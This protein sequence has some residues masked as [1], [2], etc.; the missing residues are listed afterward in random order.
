MQTLP[1]SL[2]V[3]TLYQMCMIYKYAFYSQKRNPVFSYLINTPIKYMNDNQC[4]YINSNHDNILR[5][6]HTIVSVFSSL[7]KPGAQLEEQA[8]Y[9]RTHA[10][11]QRPVGSRESRESASS[12]QT[13]CTAR[14]LDVHCCSGSS[15][16]LPTATR[17]HAKYWSLTP[18]AVAEGKKK[19]L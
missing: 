4:N 9:S 5:S 13:A 17:H 10:R 14:P 2:D 1:C 8:R 12:K 16:A 7:G 18:V 19:H 3:S 6:E 11:N 15:R